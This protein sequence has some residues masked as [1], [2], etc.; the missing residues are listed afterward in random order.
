MTKPVQIALCTLLLTLSA[1]AVFVSWR[2]ARMLQSVD[3]AAVSIG[4]S[5]SGADL[6][7]TTSRMN[8]TLDLINRPCA[9][10]DSTGHLLPDGPICEIDQMIHDVRKITTASGEQVKQTGKLIE[11]TTQTMSEAG[12]AVKDTAGHL[13]K[14]ADATTLLTV[15]ATTDLQT[16]NPSFAALAP[17]VAAFDDATASLNT[18]LKDEAI[19]K[20]VDNL[21]AMT[22]SGDVIL[23]NA[24]QVSTKAKEDY[25]KARTPWG[26]FVTTG[27]D[28]IHLGAYAAR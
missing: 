26:K 14:A 28:L 24:A 13:N 7:A 18:L 12:Q 2:L 5:V 23:A 20:T 22:T 21:A 27:L 17:G 1:C 9:S 10:V 25:M 11:A 4:S 3:N 6:A 19:K 8:A 16:L 15:Q